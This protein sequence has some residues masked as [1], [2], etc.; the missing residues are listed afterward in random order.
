MINRLE[1]YS[2]LSS[3]VT[4]CVSAINVCATVAAIFLPVC[5]LT[6]LMKPFR[7]APP[8]FEAPLAR[9]Q[10]ERAEGDE[11]SHVVARAVP[12]KFEV[13]DGSRSPGRGGDR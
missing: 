1:H 8:V 12:A 7:T 6:S 11:L 4:D 3:A 2:Q 9:E 5:A 13:A 10:A